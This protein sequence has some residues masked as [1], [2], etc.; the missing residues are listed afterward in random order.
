LK[1]LN[2]FKQEITPSSDH[3]NETEIADV[4]NQGDYDLLIGLESILKVLWEKL[5]GS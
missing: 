1:N 5:S 4:A 2:K 3:L